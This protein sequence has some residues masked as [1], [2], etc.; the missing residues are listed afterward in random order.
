M[1]RGETVHHRRSPGVHGPHRR[2]HRQIHD[3]TPEEA[4]ERLTPLISPENNQRLKARSQVVLLTTPLLFAQGIVPEPSKAV[5]ELLM[6]DG[7]AR[8]V[9]LP[10]VGVGSRG[11]F[12]S[13]PR[14]TEGYVPLAYRD[15]ATPYTYEYL[16]DQA[17]V[18]LAFNHSRE[19]FPNQFV[20]FSD[21]MIA[22]GTGKQIDRVVIDLRHNGGGALDYS[23]ALVR[24]AKQSA[25]SQAKYYGIIGRNTF[26]AGMFHAY[27]LQQELG[28]KLIG[29]P[30]GGKPWAWGYV[31]QFSL[32]YYRLNVQYS[33]EFYKLTPE[34]RDWLAP[35]IQPDLKASDYFS[36]FDPWLAIALAD[37]AKPGSLQLDAPRSE[38]GS[39][40]NTP[41]TRSNR[42]RRCA[43]SPPER[44]SPSYSVTPRP[45]S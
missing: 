9:E 33:T 13:A 17:T 16:P 18:Y 25:W 24:Y 44:R 39:A 32:P 8:T 22:D 35:D 12:T 6:P 7:A 30:T 20:S 28:A 27:Q 1:V 37:G 40:N 3:S 31:G 11:A 38:D 26:S 15:P 29:E 36:R 42:A 10:S 23:E 45:K 21:N 2:A 34:D 14:R 5:L 4:L 19:D 43:S 41:I